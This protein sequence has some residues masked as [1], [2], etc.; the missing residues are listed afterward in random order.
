MIVNTFR[1]VYIELDQD[2]VTRRHARSFFPRCIARENIRCDVDE[3]LWPDGQQCMDDQE[4]EENI[5]EGKEGDQERE[6][7]D[8]DQ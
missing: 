7:E 1:H 3:N 5:Q 2:L 4:E 8:S 6:G